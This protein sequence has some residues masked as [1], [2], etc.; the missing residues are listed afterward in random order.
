MARLIVVLALLPLVCSGQDEPFKLAGV[1]GRC[2]VIS[3]VEWAMSKHRAVGTGCTVCHGASQGH[4]IDERNNIKPEKLP[5]E[6]AIG[7][8]CNSCHDAG[9]PKSKQKVDCQ[10]CHHVH[11]L[12]DPNR[13]ATV[14]AAIPA[15]PP[16]TRRAPEIRDL[17]RKI[18]VAGIEMVLV[19]GGEFDMGSEKWPSAGPVHTVRVNPYY[20]G[21]AEVSTAQWRAVM[22]ASAASG[23]DGARAAANVSWLDCQEFIK[24]LNAIAA[25][26]GLRLPTEAEWELAA[27]RASVLGLAHMLDGVW[28]WTASD[29]RAYLDTG[30]APARWKV[31]RGASDGDT[32]DL[33]D[34]AFRHGERPDRRL[35]WNGLRLA[36][37]ARIK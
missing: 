13:P 34:V 25:G 11:A 9:C 18:A 37:E 19:D 8:F 30:A 27:R 12:V 23:E 28:E 16:P 5:R 22:G 3:V 26:G 33:R 24:R 35:R 17:P 36:R 20:I 31:L 15:V 1:C 21:V 32:P 7:P 29:Y 10:K 2:H 6:K 4:V 14:S